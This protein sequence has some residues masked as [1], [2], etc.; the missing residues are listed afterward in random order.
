MIRFKRSL[1]VFLCVAAVFGLLNIMPLTA[2]AAPMTSS[3]EMID[4]LKQM[5]GFNAKPFWDYGQYTVGYGTRCPEDKR[6]YYSTY[7]ITEEEALILLRE[8]LNEFEEQVNNFIVKRNLTV[9]QGQF[10]ALVSISYNCGGAWMNKTNTNLFR[11][12]T[13]GNKGEDLIYAFTLYS[14]AGGSY[15][16]GLVK[17]RLSEA[18]MYING[19]YKASNLKDGIP[20][21]YKWVFLDGNGATIDGGIFG[22]DSNLNTKVKATFTEI[23]T[24]IDDNGNPFA[25]KLAGWYTASGKKVEVLDS[26][27]TNGQTL[28][29]KW[30]DPTGN[31][32]GGSTEE[33]VEVPITVTGSTVNIRKGPGTGYDKNGTAKKGE[34]YTVT[35]VATGSGYTW[36]KIG[37]DKWICL[38]YTDY[39]APEQKPDQDEPQPEIGFPKTGTVNTDDVNVRSGPSTGNSKV[40][41]LD[42]G[43]QV[44][45]VEEDRSSNPPWGKLSDGNWIRLDFVDYAGS[46]IVSVELIQ[47]PE[48]TSYESI[49]DM[50]RL[51][52]S[53]LFVAY[54]DGSSEA[55]TL[56]S[57]M[58][59]DY[60]MT[61]PKE[62][63]VTAQYKGFTVTFTVAVVGIKLTIVKQPS[64]AYADAGET[65][66][67]SLT[68]NG[69]GLQY[70]WFAKN[71][72][73]EAFHATQQTTAVYTVEMTEELDGCKL[74][75]QITDIGGETMNSD[76]VTLHLGAMAAP[77]VITAQPVDTYVASGSRASTTV[78]ATGEGLKY[79]WYYKDKD[80]KSYSKSSVTSATYACSMTAE[81]DGREIYCEITDSHGNTV[82]TETVTLNIKR[83]LSI[84]K[85]PAN[86][87]AP[88]GTTASVSVQAAGND[89]QYV[90]YVKQPGGSAFEA[91]DV[92]A[93]TYTLELSEENNGTQ[94]Y[95]VL[96]DCHGKSVTSNTVTISVKEQAS[97]PTIEITKQ[98][99]NVVVKIGER[100]ATSVTA[101]GEGLKY[102]WYYKDKNDSTWTKS[103]LTSTTYALTLTAARDGRQAYCQI[104]DKYG[105]TVKTDTITLSSKAVVTPEPEPEPEPQGKIEITKQ[106][107]NVVVKIGE[108]AA[109]SVTAKGEGLKYQWYYKDKKDT[110]WTKSSL[111]ST[112]YALTLTAARDGRQAYCQITDKYGNTVKTDTITLSSKAVVTPEPEPEPEPQGK[113]EITKQP[114]NVVVKIGERAATSVT[115][116]GEGLK[117][118]WYYKD[119][120]DGIWNKSTLTSNTYACTVNASRVGR[121]IYCV[122]TD[123]YGNSVQTD[124]IK[125]TTVDA[126]RAENPDYQDAVEQLRAQMV[127]REAVITVE[128]LGDSEVT[129][130]N[131]P[132]TDLL[133]AA[134]A[135]TGKPKEG[136]YL[137][138]HCK[139]LKYSIESTVHPGGHW[140]TATYTITYRTTA[141]Q[142]D[143]VDKA[144][145]R[146]LGELDVSNASDYQKVK[147]IYDYLC[148][149]V[150][151]DYVGSALGDTDIYSAHGALVKGNAVCHGFATAFYRL[152]LEL[153][154]DVRLIAGKFENSAHGWNI[155]KI[156]GKYYN[157]DATRDAG[158]APS[159][160]QY[161]LKSDDSMPKHIRSSEYATA[162]FY[163]DYPMA[164]TDYAQ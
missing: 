36:G 136:D 158:A 40:Y 142:E 24:G 15:L 74:Y 26:T 46:G 137:Y 144:V 147:A 25:Y 102:Q 44:T 28:T 126:I 37:T 2:K 134:I 98:P 159:A 62:A 132:G 117:Y 51:E 17:R 113:I 121:L 90:W 164:T 61:G 97:V 118:Q 162:Q 16:E 66:K 106:P 160:Y 57:E 107:Q 108:R 123:K 93:A 131:N 116:K 157:V 81:R 31:V 95:C 130:E 82:T 78:T 129:K 55:L 87:S 143:E 122:I 4:V 33:S 48:K 21:N 149:N 13:S 10:D 103:S 34:T 56:T 89:V 88:V 161:F 125:F 76:V 32:L 9:D 94:V 155:V 59:K 104:T 60:S 150:I 111:T 18:N 100:A 12:V 138:R 114:Q 105:N 71:K 29:A 22:Y 69:D 92:N 133:F 68:A 85:Q 45:I 135:H 99:Q 23:P 50:L 73:E 52:G 109:T 20:A 27:L 64:N 43:D 128:Y 53:I 146:I 14:T 96:S 75:C 101:K 83:T 79:Q 38:D 49:H 47:L 54:A 77:I 42:K 8:E 63:T 140:V 84:T 67:V 65:A 30:V 70:L 3:V 119:T 156:N 153:D 1:C 5:E 35:A 141:E 19:I 58:I 110:T 7:G 115:A 152:A 6:A 120:D 41:Q 151:V 124:T 86:V 163:K 91:S 148:K 154:L 39:K 139:S 127:K 112:T 145:A 11:A 80:D 72:D